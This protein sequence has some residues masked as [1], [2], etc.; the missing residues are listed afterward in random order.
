MS[1]HKEGPVDPAERLRERERRLLSKYGGTHPPR[2]F[3]GENLQSEDPRDAEHWVG[4]YTELVQFIHTLIESAAEASPGHATPEP[5]RQT[6]G[7]RGMRLQAQVLELHLA[8]WTDRLNRLR[9]NQRLI[10]DPPE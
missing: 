9:A 10:Q 4:V 5:G 6:N 3:D 1:A 8:F 2:S 7:V